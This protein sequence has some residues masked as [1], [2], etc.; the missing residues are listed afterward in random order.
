MTLLE[1]E[2]LRLREMEEGDRAFL[3]EVLNEPAFVRNVGDRGVRTE[4]AAI[5]YLRER[6]APSYSQNGFGLWLVELKESDE[7]IGMCGLLR[8]ETLE[9]VDVGFS[10]LERYWSRGFAF[11][12]AAATLDFGWG[13]AKLPRIVAIT[14]AQN[15]SSVRLLEK[16]GLRFEKMIRLT[17][18]DP[19]LM[20][21]AIASPDRARAEPGYCR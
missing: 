20:L 12:A 17:P 18:D 6:I 9:D 14:V 8:R 3:L 7:P 1:T 15:R 4:A 21:F 16:L 2:R 10:F 13:V 19:E 11:E 5:D